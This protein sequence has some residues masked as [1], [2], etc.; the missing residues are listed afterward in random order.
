[1]D[2]WFGMKSWMER[3]YKLLV[4]SAMSDVQ[5]GGLWQLFSHN[6]KYKE[7]RTF[8]NGKIAI[9]FFQDETLMKTA[10]TCFKIAELD[11]SIVTPIQALETNI[12]P[13]SM[14]L[15]KD[16]VMKLTK[17]SKEDLVKLAV[18]LGKPSSKW[19]LFKMIIIR[20]NH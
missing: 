8:W 12:E 2:S 3:H 19:Y 18:A 17:F 4:T 14:Q 6:L 20:W 1:M 16:A 15:S 11:S 7:Y 10:S 13:P 5:G 9:T